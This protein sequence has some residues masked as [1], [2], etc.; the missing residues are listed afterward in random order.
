MKPPMAS[1]HRLRLARPDRLC[2]PK[3]H[4]PL[5]G[6]IDVAAVDAA[7]AERNRTGLAQA[8]GQ[9]QGSD[10]DSQPKRWAKSLI[11]A[12]PCEMHLALALRCTKSRTGLLPAAAP[13]P[14]M[15]KPLL[16]RGAA[17][18]GSERQLPGG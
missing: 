16:P 11:R 6:P 12:R 7:A 3:G 10:R 8:A 15:I 14:A 13:L 18:S 4:Q 5:D 9:V 2:L 17:P 1:G